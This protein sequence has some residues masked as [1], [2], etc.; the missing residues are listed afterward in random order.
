M[1]SQC[2]ETL[3]VDWLFTSDVLLILV[4]DMTAGGDLSLLPHVLRALDQIPGPDKG[5]LLAR[6]CGLR[7]SDMCAN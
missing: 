1:D 2:S 5:P 4:S 6:I 7:L 3:G